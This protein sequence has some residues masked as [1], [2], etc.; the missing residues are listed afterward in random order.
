MKLKIKNPEEETSNLEH[1]E[2]SNISY[3]Y[4]DE[5]GTE[6][7]EPVKH[8]SRRERKELERKNKKKK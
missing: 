5:D 7:R 4:T 3:D 2:V 8:L 6:E 1:E